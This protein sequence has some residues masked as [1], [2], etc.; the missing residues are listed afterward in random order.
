MHDN[1]SFPTNVAIASNLHFWLAKSLYLSLSC[2]RLAYVSKHPIYS[3]EE[4]CPPQQY[5]SSLDRLLVYV[6]SAENSTDEA[7]RQLLILQR[8][9]LRLV[10]FSLKS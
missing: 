4:F 6:F 7:K 10:V 5:Q 9:E 3:A 2:F 1:G 8:F